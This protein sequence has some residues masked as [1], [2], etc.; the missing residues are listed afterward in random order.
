[1]ARIITIFTLLI[2]S[3]SCRNETIDESRIKKIGQALIQMDTSASKFSIQEIVFIGDGLKREISQLQAKTTTYEFN[4]RSGDLNY[5]FGNNTADCILTINTKFKNI[6]IRL[7]YNQYKNKYDILG[8]KTLAKGK[9][10]NSK[11]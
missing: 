9:L 3:L 2:F 7:K 10:S 11:Q 8:W 1:M 5:P 6:E 4:V